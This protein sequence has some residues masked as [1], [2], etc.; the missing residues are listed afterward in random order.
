MVHSR[1]PLNHLL[2]SG[3]RDAYPRLELC[4]EPPHQV[5]KGTSIGILLY[6]EPINEWTSR[7]RHT[8]IGLP[9]SFSLARYSTMNTAEAFVLPGCAV[10]IDF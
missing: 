7:K 4:D 6:Q 1:K 3:S 9:L 10:Q 8:K 2:D 5:I